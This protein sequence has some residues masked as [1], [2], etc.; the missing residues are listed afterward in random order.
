MGKVPMNTVML[1]GSQRANYLVEYFVADLFGCQ[2]FVSNVKKPA[3]PLYLRNR[4]FDRLIPSCFGG[5]DNPAWVDKTNKCGIWFEDENNRWRLFEWERDKQ[6]S[7][8]VITVRSAG[9]MRIALFGF[10][11]RSTNAICNEL[12]RRPE[13]FW[14]V[15]AQDFEDD[16]KSPLKAAKKKRASRKKANPPTAIVRNSN[17]IGIYICRVYFSEPENDAEPWA[18][19][20]FDKDKVEVKPF[21]RSVL[22]KYLPRR[23]RSKGGKVRRKL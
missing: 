14:P 9:S 5:R 7:G 3:V 20:D 6:D 2:P 13:N 11:G 22:E 1:I 17:E 10:T 8:A 15:N 12:I 16:E 19:K 18:A 4:T 23:G 21:H